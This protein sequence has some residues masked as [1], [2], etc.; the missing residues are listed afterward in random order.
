[1]FN[2]AE[3]PGDGD[4][5]FLLRDLSGSVGGDDGV[6]DS[7]FELVG[8]QYEQPRLASRRHQ[9][10]VLIF[11]LL[12]RPVAKSR[13][14]VA[15]LF[16]GLP[17]TLVLQTVRSLHHA[18]PRSLVVLPFARVNLNH[19]QVGNVILHSE[20]VLQCHVGLS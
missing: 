18:E 3:L 11:T 16:V 14:A 1:M 9:N 6:L 7:V 10:V 17:L 2:D 8:S 12:A 19:V 13:G 4:V 15:V 5:G 20:T